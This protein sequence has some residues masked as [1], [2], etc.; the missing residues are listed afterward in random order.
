MPGASNRTLI[1]RAIYGGRKGRSAQKRLAKGT[2]KLHR[3]FIVL[4]WFAVQPMAPTIPWV[5]G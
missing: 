2:P 3:G 5:W 1:Q 4:Q